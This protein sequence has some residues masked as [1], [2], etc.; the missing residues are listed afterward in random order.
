MSQL[1]DNL[2]TCG[3]PI[4]DDE[5]IAYL[6]ASLDEDYNLMFTSIVTRADPL[7]PSE[8]YA[9]LLSFEH[10][11]NL[12]VNSAYSGSLFAMTASHGHGYSGGRAAGPPSRGSGRGRGR[13]RTQRG[14]FSNSSG[15]G[16]SNSNNNSTFRPNAKSTTRSVT[17]PRSVGTTMRMIPT[18]IH[19]QRVWQS[20]LT[21]T[22]TLIPMLHTTSLEILTSLQCMTH[23]VAM[24]K[25]TF[26]MNLVCTL[27]ILILLLFPH[28]P[29]LLL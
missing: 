16:A 19:S 18:L 24:T 5:F 9:Q 29:V 2:A 11:T 22:S 14:S 3:T 28:L 7:A 27:L 17:P 21:I 25:S 13:G 20:L 1:A 15:C 12:Q 26:Q 23:M 6:L 10:H 4:R 8:L